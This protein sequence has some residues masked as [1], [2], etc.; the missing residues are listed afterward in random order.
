MRRQG[1]FTL[2]ELLVVIAIIAILMGILMPALNRVRTQARGAACKSNLH[3][4]GLMFAMYTDDNNGRFFNGLVK[5]S[6]SNVA[7]GEWWRV[8]MWDLS[9]D[10]KMWLCPTAFKSRSANAYT[11]TAPAENPFDAWRV[12][13]AQ[14]G[15]E[16]SYAPNGWTC[17][18]PAG[19]TSMWGR[20]PAANYWRTNLVKGADNI[21]VFTEAWWVDGWPLD[22]DS[23]CP[24]GERT[25][26]LSSDEMQRMCVNR[27]GSAQF[28]LF[29]DW[30]VKRVSLKQLWQLKWHRNFNTAGK[31][32][33]AGNVTDD[34]W[35]A[36]MAG[37]PDAF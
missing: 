7:D 29:A 28:C 31:W 37:I 10:K 20:G 18:I 4:W 5:N 8:S 26:T 35:P 25:P 2:I 15:D 3:Q 6:T 24:Q 13:A 34:A 22:T 21:P 36:W 9:K 23:P 1:G 11:T 17:N 27:H 32:T 16:G 14:G 33:K 19:Y 12:T 30:S